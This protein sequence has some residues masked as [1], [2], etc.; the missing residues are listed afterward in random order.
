MGVTSCKFVFHKSHSYHSPAVARAA[1][2]HTRPLYKRRDS[3]SRTK[4]VLSSNDT[5]RFSS[6]ELRASAQMYR[7]P[8]GLS[9]AIESNPELNSKRQADHPGLFQIVPTVLFHRDNGFR[10]LPSE[11]LIIV[12]HAETPDESVARSIM[13]KRCS[14]T[15]SIANFRSI[16][17]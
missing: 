12:D 3:L 1:R 8:R 13:R 7:N 4:P 15:R 6:V 5:E 2:S 9:S 17:T 16:I 14:S 10:L 11:Q